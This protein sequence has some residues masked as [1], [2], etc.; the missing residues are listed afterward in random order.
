MII[1]KLKRQKSKYHPIDYYFGSLEEFPEFYFKGSDIKR[2]IYAERMCKVIEKHN[3]YLLNFV[4]KYICKVN[5]EWIVL[6]EKIDVAKNDNESLLDVLVVQQLTTLAEETGYIDWPNFMKDR[7]GK[8]VFFDTE[9]LSFTTDMSSV[10][11]CPACS[12]VVYAYKV[13]K[14][15]SK[16]MTIEAKEWLQKRIQYLVDCNKD[17]YK[18]GFRDPH[19][20]SRTD[21]D[22]LEVDFEEVK[23]RFEKKE[24]RLEKEKKERIK[25]D[26]LEERRL[27]RQEEED[28]RLEKQKK[29]L[30]EF[31]KEKLEEEN[32]EFKEK[33]FDLSAY[34]LGFIGL[35]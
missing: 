29:E 32:Q 28:K 26:M 4:K 1:A 16:K 35:L 19:I 13:L 30:E 24:K 21:L 10:Y 14:Y 27:Q 2:I 31:V 23:I 15:L 7:S 33:K 34:G 25:K 6:A 20:T 9:E 12:K 3:L 18:N 8:L 11:G 22:D 17:E 5:D